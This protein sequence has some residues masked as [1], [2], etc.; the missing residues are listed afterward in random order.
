MNYAAEV[1]ASVS[2]RDILEH[3]GYDTSRSGRI[4]CP[5]H[6]GKDRNFAYRDKSFHC[7]VCGA[8]GT[9]LDFVMA[10]QGVELPDAIRYV[11]D[12]F[13]L[14]LPI[15]RE[16][17]RAEQTALE[18]KARLRRLERE[19]KEHELERLTIDYDRTLS[20]WVRLD[21]ALSEKAPEGPLDA[22][23]VEWIEAVKRL[24]GAEYDLTVAETE[25]NNFEHGM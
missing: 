14:N 7:Y 24:S 17:T 4:Q 25:L 2:M 23:D 15:G 13:G 6:H 8:K 22:L 10:Y 20:E 3:F 5:L 21:R 9:V 19:R 12:S 16:P 18:R 11:N 1:K